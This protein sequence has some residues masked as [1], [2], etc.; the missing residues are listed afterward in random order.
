[1]NPIG[2]NTS[3]HRTLC[4]YLHKAYSD[5]VELGYEWGGAVDEI[6]NMNAVGLTRVVIYDREKDEITLGT[7][8]DLKPFSD[9]GKD[10]SA[11]IAGTN[12]QRLMHVFAHR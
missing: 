4:G 6:L 2:E 12:W 7:T 1:M 8:S 3:E 10:C 11:I 9:Y 5:G